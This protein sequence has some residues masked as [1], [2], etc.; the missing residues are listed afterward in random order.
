MCSNYQVITLLSLPRN[1]SARVLK[2]SLK[3]GSIGGFKGDRTSRLHV[4]VGLEKANDLPVG[5]YCQ[6]MG[7]RSIDVSYLVLI[8][9][10]WHLC[11][12]SRWSQTVFH[13][14]LGWPRH[15]CNWL[16]WFVWLHQSL[17]F[18]NQSA[19]QSLTPWFSAR[20]LS[21]SPK[22]LFTSDGKMAGEL[23]RHQQ[24]W[25]YF[26]Q[27]LWRRGSRANDEP[28]E[29]VWASDHNVSWTPSFG[30][31]YRHIQMEG[32]LYLI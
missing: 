22:V 1:A 25:R 23:E 10:D 16:M 19:T 28:D 30:G 31:F 6:S 5:L 7:H 15:I 8:L 11:P 21:F 9:P 27:T 17:T 32:D 24:W 20:K 4:F 14:V 18:S 13:L 26:I 2:R 3:L 12:C 29:V